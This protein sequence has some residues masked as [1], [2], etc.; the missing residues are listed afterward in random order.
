M[1]VDEFALCY[2]TNE[3]NSHNSDANSIGDNSNENSSD[4]NSNA[5]NGDASI[6]LPDCKGPLMIACLNGKAFLTFYSVDSEQSQVETIHLEQ[7]S[8]ILLRD[9]I[10]A[11]LSFCESED[12]ARRDS[13]ECQIICAYQ[14][15]REH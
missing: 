9:G 12:G 5:I 13:T 15:V 6:D 2:V 10:K 11:Y 7:G 1:P 4:D 14:P 3:G 8:V